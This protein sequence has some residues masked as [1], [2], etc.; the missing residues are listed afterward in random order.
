MPGTRRA[1]LLVAL[2][3]LSSSRAFA[4]DPYADYRIPDHHWLSWTA[5][6]NGSGNHQ[7]GQGLFGLASNGGFS[8]Q[9]GSGFSAGYDSDAHQ[10]RYNLVL[11]LSGSRGYASQ[12]QL[13]P[14][15]TLDQLRRD[16][17]ATENLSGSMFAGVFPSRRI[18]RS[19]R[20]CWPRRGSHAACP[21]TIGVCSGGS[22]SQD[23]RS[24]SRMPFVRRPTA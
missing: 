14:P 18:R 11:S 13:Q 12:Q 23:T 7:R 24:M 10:L 9:G 16:R 22:G 1:S 20:G 6:V 4:D 17:N 5:S 19:R 3:C 15:S 8:G 21:T 2:L